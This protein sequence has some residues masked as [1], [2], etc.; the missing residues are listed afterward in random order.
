[1]IAVARP[2][3]SRPSREPRRRRNVRFPPERRLGQR[4]GRMIA[5]ARPCT[6]LCRH[7]SPREHRLPVE[8]S[9]SPTPQQQST[10]A[11]LLGQRSPEPLVLLVEAGASGQATGGVPIKSAGQTWGH[12][13]L[14]GRGG[15]ALRIYAV[16]A[17]HH[18][19]LRSRVVVDRL[20][21]EC[22]S[23]RSHHGD[24]GFNF[25]EWRFEE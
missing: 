9:L 16:S 17:P 3:R 7:S 10:P 2:R 8:P 21:N 11:G 23:Q 13:V 15:G 1:M 22:T 25:A 19:W 20:S 5:P 14:P 18:L 12:R 4:G 6:N 24:D